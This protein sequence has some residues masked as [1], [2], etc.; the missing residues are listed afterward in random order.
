MNARVLL[1]ARMSG[2]NI[3]IVEAGYMRDRVRTFAPRG[4]RVRA[5]CLSVNRDTV[6]Q[7][8]RGCTFC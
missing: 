4:A 5:W 7:P 1:M 3:T 6:N 2:K 8:E